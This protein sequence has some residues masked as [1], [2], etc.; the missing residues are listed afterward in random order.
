[1][2]RGPYNCKK[3]NKGMYVHLLRDTGANFD[4]PGKLLYVLVMSA[5]SRNLS[6]NYPWCISVD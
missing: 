4:I 6:S 2:D 5:L 3:N 1:M